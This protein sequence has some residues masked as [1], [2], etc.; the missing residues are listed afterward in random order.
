MEFNY[1]REKRK[2][3][4]EWE[5]LQKEYVAAGMSED[6]IAQM[7]AFD[8]EW[9]RSQRVYANHN[10][11]LPDEFDCEENGN[12]KLFRKFA[13]LSV[14]FGK[15]GLTGRYEWL[16]GIENEKLYQRLCSLKQDDLELVTLIA[17]DG[18][19]QADV[20]HMKG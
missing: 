12:S 9:F 7:K 14:A 13:T 16:M 18:Y 2:F 10:Q 4:K 1:A 6:A 3:D 8:W 5:Q 17:I 11:L 19:K 20:A 15:N